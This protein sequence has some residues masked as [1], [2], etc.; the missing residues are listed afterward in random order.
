MN[1]GLILDEACNEYVDRILNDL[2]QDKEAFQDPYI[3]PNK[4]FE[5]SKK[6][7]FVNYTGE[8]SMYNCHIYGLSTLHRD[9]D[10]IVDK[11][12][13]THLKLW[14]GAG[15]L[16]LK[17]SGKLKLMG[18]GPQ[19][20][21]DATI[22]Y[23]NM[24]LDMTPNKDDNPKITKFDME[25]VKGKEIKVSGMGPLSF[26]LN[27]YVEFVGKMFHGMIEKGIET[28]MKDFL[29]KKLKGYVIPEACLNGN[30]YLV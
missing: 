28:R 6:V 21:V 17:G 30:F 8:A 25:S 5:V 18:H 27:K 1:F 7:L 23:V 24:K 26:L 4:S 19:V 15:E 16:K 11:K 22:K 29:N 13:T 9:G 14:L 2:K 20:I 10:V 12:K 3:M